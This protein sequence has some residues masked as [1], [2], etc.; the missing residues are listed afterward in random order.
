[1]VG[2]LARAVVPSLAAGA[3]AAYFVYRR[4]RRSQPPQWYADLFESSA[5][6]LRVAEWENGWLWRLRNGWVGTDYA[7][8]PSAAVHVAGYALSGSGVGTKLVGAVHVSAAHEL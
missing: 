7:H 4:C 6:R 8:G 2:G 3:V 1:M 5:S